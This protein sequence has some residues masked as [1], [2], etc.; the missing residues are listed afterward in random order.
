MKCCLILELQIKPIKIFKLDHPAFSEA[1]PGTGQGMI[2]DAI[3]ER[4]TL[5]KCIME[6]QEN[7]ASWDR[8]F[9]GTAFWLP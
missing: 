3:P 5:A 1:D 4:A 9:L 8:E 2:L 7:Q 6:T